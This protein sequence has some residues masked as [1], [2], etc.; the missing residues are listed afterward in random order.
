[1]RKKSTYQDLK[2]TYFSQVKELIE[3]VRIVTN[4]LLRIIN[5]SSEMAHKYRQSSEREFLD[6][7][8]TWYRLANRITITTIETACYKM[9]QITLLMFDTTG[10]PLSPKD[11]D[12]LLEKKSDGSPH[13]LKP[14]ENVKFAFKMLAEALGFP[15][16][17]KY[18]KEWSNFLKVIRKRHAL[19]HPKSLVDLKMSVQDHENTAHAFDWFNSI[20][21]QFSDEMKKNQKYKVKLVIP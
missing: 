13:Y 16:K 19:T 8:G 6:E 14:Q 12:K 15:F 4:D 3:I 17:I 11:R 18:D 10:K 2:K 5:K 7:Q 1:M 9:K 20:F 21:N